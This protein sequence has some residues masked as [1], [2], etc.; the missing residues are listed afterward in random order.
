MNS[1]LC[2]ID[3]T[4]A[5]SSSLERQSHPPLKFQPRACKPRANCSS[6]VNFLGWFRYRRRFVSSIPAGPENGVAQ[7]LGTTRDQQWRAWDSRSAEAGVPEKL[8]RSP[9]KR[10]MQGRLASISWIAGPKTHDSRYLAV[11]VPAED[12]WA[13]RFFPRGVAYV[14]SVPRSSGRSD[15]VGPHETVKTE[16]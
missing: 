5:S 14:R 12:R 11:K 13:R 8:R 3:H 4:E 16:R 10:C 9:C 7:L 15:H 6:L 2:F 1:P